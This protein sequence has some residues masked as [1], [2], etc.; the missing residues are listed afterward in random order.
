MPKKIQEKIVIEGLKPLLEQIRISMQALPWH[1]VQQQHRVNHSSQ[2]GMLQELAGPAVRKAESLSGW[3]ENRSNQ[4]NENCSQLFPGQTKSGTH[5]VQ[6]G[7]IWNKEAE[8]DLAAAPSSALGDLNK[9]QGWENTDWGCQK[10]RW[11]NTK[12]RRRSEVDK[13]FDDGASNL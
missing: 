13:S 3:Q 4:G 1:C 5:W 9:H 2:S 7:P 11:V 8:K 6:E 10:K 12:W